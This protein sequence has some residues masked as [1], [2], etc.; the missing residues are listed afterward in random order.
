MIAVAYLA[1]LVFAGDAIG[2]R[3]FTYVTPLQRLATAFLIGVL[4][5]TWVSYLAAAAFANTRDPLAFGNLIAAGS[6]GL[7]GIWLRRRPRGQLMRP[8]IARPLDRW[9]WL[10]FG[11]FALLVGWM[12]THTFH[13]E[14]GRLAIATSLWSD[15]GPTTAI[16][17]NFALGDNF[18][19][20]YPHFAGEP[21]RYH[22]LYYFQVGNLTRLGFDPAL[23][24][25]VLSIGSLVSM[26][27][28]TA[29]LGERLFRS[30]WVGRI[31]AGLFFFH[32][33]LSF[34]PWIGSFPSVGEA[35]ARIPDLDQYMT[36]G[37]PYRGEE[38][39]IWTQNTFLN[40]RHLA[41]ALGILLVIVLFLWD[42]L[43]YGRDRVE[44][45]AAPARRTN[46]L[47]A[48]AAGAAAH[49]REDAR[50]PRAAVRRATS[51]PALPGYV[52]CGLLAGMLPLWNGAIFLAAAFVL[53]VWFVLFPHRLSMLALAATAGILALP[54]V[55]SVQPAP[56]AGPQ[57]Y[58]AFHWGYILDDPT[59]AN[60][61]AYL[62]FIFGPKV[63]LAA[64]G[65]FGGTWRR[66]R[67]LIAF[68]GLVAVAFLLQLS[69]ETLGNH[70][71]LHAWLLG[72]N[73]FAA[74]GL[75]R[76][77]RARR[78][79]RIPA[80][81]VALGLA[82]VIVA[83]GVIDLMPIRNMRTIEVATDGDPLFEWVKNE[84]EPT[85]VFLTDLH[86]VDPILLAGR[87]I[88]Y[89]WPYYAW[90]AGYDVYTRERWYREVFALRS[91]RDLAWRLTLAGIDYVA[92]DDKLRGN[93]FAPRLNEE[94]YQASFEPVFE[95][96]QGRYAHLTIYRVPDAAEIVNLPDA[97]A[98]DMYAGGPGGEPGRFSAPGGL[99]VDRA[100]RLYVAD[101]G[102]D[103]IQRFS[104]S[105]NL[106][107]TIGEPGT[108]PGQL[109]A[110][111]GVAITPGD[112]L[113]VADTGN[114]RIQEY[115]DRGVFVR[116][117][118]GPPEGLTEPVDVAT[119][120]DRLFVLDAGAGRIVRLDPDGTVTSWGSVGAG[121]GQLT[122]P[123][124][125][126]FAMGSLV[127][128]DGGNAR[129]AVFR[130]D[131]TWER[132]WPVPE[133]QGIEKPGD[134]AADTDAVWASS[135]ATN[136][137]LVYRRD[138]SPIGQLTA[139]EPPDLDG[140]VGLALKP[141]RALYVLNAAA[142]RISLLTRVTP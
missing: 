51:D 29:T 35:L 94:V 74:Y 66:Q 6:L 67:V 60:V 62:G 48:A 121:D 68:A 95:D 27:V 54:Q 79:V 9:D 25:N 59:L 112:H 134:V 90:S 133:W 99:A 20:E 96:P 101:T 92:F 109:D 139:T 83:G 120:G 82:G 98:E 23:A 118:S 111:S 50:H 119:D 52:L 73:L 24:N 47:S 113:Y 46:R 32:G 64:F 33:A 122:R 91:A 49:L 58:P 30:P 40:Q 129:V 108:G 110:P 55:L 56:T 141:G 76:L 11:A 138:G 4:V 41:S 107:G 117:W 31:G 142:N 16:A 103:R 88:H 132:S 81:L 115:D 114:R 18:P 100:G 17:Q 39:G 123:T 135:P 1:V 2:R 124:G 85:A 71:F 57:P 15:F 104:S 61:G 37:F 14:A 93:G 38:W 26:L 87:R 131:G 102:N 45:N 78:A 19:T 137:I 84:T 10:T 42:R 106:L 28:L 125:I 36:S 13:Y 72:L 75:A 126:A 127:V 128:A 140:P 3:F 22:F 12:M 8:R 5:G 44:P 130:D 70:K 116:E 63:L 97:P 86:V 80:R 105:G 69:M 89:G 43:P 65:L 136:A 34:V 77:W 53:G 7:L 21:I